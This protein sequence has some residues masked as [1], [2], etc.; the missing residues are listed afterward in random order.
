MVNENFSDIPSWNYYI[1]AWC[2]MGEYELANLQYAY[3]YEKLGERLDKRCLN[4][5]QPSPD[6]KL[7]RATE[8]IPES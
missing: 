4:I 3:D 8:P 2:I 6:F 7:T 1:T 5:L